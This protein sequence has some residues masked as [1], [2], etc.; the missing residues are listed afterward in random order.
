M[1]VAAPLGLF[2]GPRV[3]ARMRTPFFGLIVAASLSLLACGPR[4]QDKLADNELATAVGGKEAVPDTRCGAQA[5]EDE[6]KRQLFAR[7]AEIRGS[8]ADDYASIAGFSLI[9]ID[10]APDISAA[11]GQM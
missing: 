5:V 3:A 2:D 7:A 4:N 1:R 11:T 8:N 9:E 10:A 6:V